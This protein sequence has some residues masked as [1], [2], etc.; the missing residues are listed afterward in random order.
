[1]SGNQHQNASV[2]ESVATVKI[3]KG[4]M[5]I[6]VG[7]DWLLYIDQAAD[8]QQSI[9][10]APVLM[11]AEPGET[12]SIVPDG[13]DVPLV[14]SAILA[15]PTAGSQSHSS[16]AG[17]LF[18]YFEPVSAAG[19]A[20][21]N[22]AKEETSNHRPWH[23]PQSTSLSS[24]WFHNLLG[25]NFKPEDLNS[26][27][28]EIK[29]MLQS[30]SPIQGG[31]NW[32]FQ[33]IAD[34]IHA[35]PSGRI[36]TEILATSVGWSSAHLRQNFRNHVG[37]TM[38]KYQIWCRFFLLANQTVFEQMNGDNPTATDRLLDAGFYDA[39]HGLRSLRK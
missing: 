31:V 16:C 14:S 25:G 4:K 37:L 21:T 38:S 26:W 2:R 33:T 8:Y 32:R 24:D 29:L 5:G 1:M 34:A 22:L 10:M 11:L 20:L 9:T 3:L 19:I 7:N 6:Y 27:V 35:N 36:D 15:G 28:A 39:S 12:L 18:L 30:E 23:L 13:T 17:G